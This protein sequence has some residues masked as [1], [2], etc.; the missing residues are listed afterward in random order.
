MARHL[1]SVMETY[2][3][4]SEDEVARMI[5]EAKENDAFELVKHS[6]IKKETR[7]K[8]AIIDSWYRLSLTKLFDDEKEPES[9]VLI[10]YKN[11]AF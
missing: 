8:G 2:R 7:K 6:S 4:D 11:G 3:V 9:E 5:K 1:I 10:E